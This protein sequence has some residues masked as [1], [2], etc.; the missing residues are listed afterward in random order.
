M[1]RK[2]CERQLSNKIENRPSKKIEMVFGGGR[3]LGI[4][5]L[6]WLCTLEW[7]Q[8]TA[9]CPVPF[10]FDMDFAD[11]L[12]K[13]IKENHLKSCVFEDLKGMKFDI[14]LSVNYHAIIPD[15]ILQ[16]CEKGFY[17]IHH[18]Y[19]LS[20]RGRNTTTHAILNTK[21]EGVYYHGTT[22]HKM[23]SQLDAG[24][25][26][27]STAC[28]IDDN[29]TA[30][31]LFCKVDALALQIIKEWIPRLA[32]QTVYPY[33]PPKEGIH[34]YKNKDLPSKEIQI[35]LLEGDVIYDYVRAFD[36]PGKEPAY[37]MK[38]GVKRNL[39]L[40]KRPGFTKK[41]EIKNCIYYTDSNLE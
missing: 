1:H 38:N 22:L 8:I 35:D 4:E 26:V 19:N 30:Y 20:L 2:N 41:I 34:Y 16:I 24:P 32:Y 23:I 37:V 28:E 39:V 10:E 13:V 15:E 14:G 5:V 3:K 6:K 33:Q 36:F 27:A 7:L 17:N 18:S 29:D 31:S 11:E 40:H 21:K 12:Q 25:V 9:V